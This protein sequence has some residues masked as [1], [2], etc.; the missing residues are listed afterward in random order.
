VALL[1]VRPKRTPGILGTVSLLGLIGVW[2]LNF[3]LVVPSLSRDRL[4]FGWIELTITAGFLGIFLL[5]AIPGLRR[6]AAAALEPISP[7]LQ[8]RME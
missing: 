7:E 6:V 4:P 3:I 5:C 8:S 2:I 1:G